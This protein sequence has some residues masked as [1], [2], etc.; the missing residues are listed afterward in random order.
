MIVRK[1]LP[2]SVTRSVTRVRA[3]RGAVQIDRDEPALIVEATGR[4]LDEVIRRNGLTQDDFISIFF[5]L[6]PDLVGEF[7]AVA[8]R[9]MGMTDVPMLCAA[10][11]AVTEG[12]PRVVR[13]LAHVQSARARG[14]VE[15]VYLDGA[16]CL[17]PDIASAS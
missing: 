5:T 11:I 14:E 4:L 12:L 9:R 6:T 17:R 1:H 7:P 3:V 8:A 15:H 10:E 2:A 16:R 13:L